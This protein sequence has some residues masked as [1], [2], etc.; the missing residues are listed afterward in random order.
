MKG[1]TPMT[2]Q[3]II[4]D[5]FN[6]GVQPIP[7]ASRVGDLVMSGG[8]YGLDPASGALPNDLGEQVALMFRHFDNIM[9]AAGAGLE[10]VVRMTFYIKDPAARA[11]INT[12]WLERFPDET[13][14]PARHTLTYTSLPA[15][16]LVQCD[17]VALVNS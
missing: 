8:I 17:F 12:H 13:S 10:H 6:H 3:S 16:M 11:H 15:N 1:K 7:A 2:R 9:A 5:N 14:R 4:L